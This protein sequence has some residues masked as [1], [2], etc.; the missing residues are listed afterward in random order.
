M[1]KINIRQLNR[2]F[3]LVLFFSPL[4][5]FS[6]TVNSYPKRNIEIDGHTVISK[7][8]M[9][10][11][12]NVVIYKDSIIQQSNKLE[13]HNFL[14][15]QKIS[16]LKK[17]TNIIILDS[18]PWIIKNKN[19]YEAFFLCKTPQ[20]RGYTSSNA[21]VFN[22]YK[23]SS[24]IAGIKLIP[25]LF[26]HTNIIQLEYN[27]FVTTKSSQFYLPIHHMTTDIE[28]KFITDSISIKDIDNDGKADFILKGT[29][30]DFKIDKSKGKLS[31]AQA[32]ISFRDNKLF[33]LYNY[34]SQILYPTDK[35]YIFKYIKTKDS[36]G[37]IIRIEKILSEVNKNKI[38]T[39]EYSIL[40]LKNISSKTNF[41]L[42]KKI[43][44]P[45]LG[46]TTE[47]NL[48][49]REG[50]SLKY[51]VITLLNKNNI[52]TIL[53]ISDKK[54]KINHLNYFWYKVKTKS[55]KIG[56][57]YGYYLKPIKGNG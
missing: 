50:A 9:N 3:L 4:F 33:W 57:I 17:G 44:F 52:V 5:A 30:Y 56:W 53:E 47:D 18:Q 7:Q 48:R 15:P 14:S 20:G 51:A 31:K 27:F 36:N 19:D 24:T 32:W 42:E 40:D 6:L 16:I 1:N 45:S 21:I 13:N 29:L 38:N 2:F 55:N 34:E 37:R 12:T 41:V 39:K 25:K 22:S 26:K 43:L 8:S 46:K 28:I 54:D 23:D 11:K 35:K 49:L 10:C